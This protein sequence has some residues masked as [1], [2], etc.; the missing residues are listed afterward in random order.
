MTGKHFN[1]NFQHYPVE[2][3]LKKKKKKDPKYKYNSYFQR[4]KER[5]LFAK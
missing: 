3:K 5:K 2:A 1:S 4:R